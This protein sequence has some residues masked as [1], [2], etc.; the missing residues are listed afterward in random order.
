MRLE[1]KA[2][3]VSTSVAGIL[4]LMKMT[5]GIFSGSIAVLASAIDSFLDLTVSLFNY[6]ALHNAEKDPD[7][8][9]HFGR[10]KIEPLAAVIEGT[11]ISLSAIFILYEALAKITHPREM[12]HMTESIVVMIIS[13]IITSFLVIFLNYVAKKTKNMVIKADALHYKTDLFSNGA[14]LFALAVISMTGEQLI[15]PLLGVGIAFYMIYSAFPIIKE[16]VLMLLDVALSAEDI[17]K[18]E[19][20]IRSEKLTTGFHDL[21]TRDSGS[22]AFITV[23]VVFNENISLLD[24]HDVTDSL[25]VKFKNALKDKKVHSIIHMDPYD[26]SIMN[27][28]EDKY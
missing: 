19:D 11:V 5:V 6:F 20:A 23:H 3:V 14:V 2:T 12:Q 22:H 9:F 21:K 18:I 16:G 8:K 24:A 7:D 17:K 28:M 25:E 1:K 27:M 4:V 13:F 15:D 10:T 26:D